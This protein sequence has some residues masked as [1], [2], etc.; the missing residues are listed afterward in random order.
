[1]GDRCA[2]PTVDQERC[3]LGQGL[4]P[5]SQII[6]TLQ[7]AGYAGAF[8]VKLIGPEIE[9]HD[10]WTLLEKSQLVFNELASAVDATRTLA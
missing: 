10:Y 3:L 8:D 4:L 5:L 6:S 1:L 9:V 2:P 7:E